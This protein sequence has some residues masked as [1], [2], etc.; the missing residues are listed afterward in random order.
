MRHWIFGLAMVLAAAAPRAS[1][2]AA[3]DTVRGFLAACDANDQVCLIDVLSGLQKAIFAG[4]A[5][6]DADLHEDEAMNTIIPWLKDAMAK[7]PAMA[8]RKSDEALVNAVKQIY[9]CKAGN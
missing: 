2:A 5:C 6:P 9:P 1:F 3:D 8:N 7:D 4:S